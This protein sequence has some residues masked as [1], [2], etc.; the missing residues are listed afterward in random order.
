MFS[1]GTR[2]ASVRRGSAG[3]SVKSSKFSHCQPLKNATPGSSSTSTAPLACPE[4]FRLL[5]KGR[6][7]V[8]AAGLSVKGTAVLSDGENPHTANRH[9]LRRASPHKQRGSSCS[10]DWPHS[11]GNWTLCSPIYT[12]GRYD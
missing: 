2:Y 1:V 10:Q 3:Q 6:P 7:A 12:N 9:L 11:L 5:G 4:P 8:V